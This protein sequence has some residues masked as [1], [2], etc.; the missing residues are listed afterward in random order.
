MDKINFVFKNNGDLINNDVVLPFG[1][2]VLKNN[3]CSITVKPKS[4]FWRLGLRLSKTD[5]IQFFHPVS[6][7]KTPEFN[8]YIDVHLS[9][10]FW[11]PQGWVD[12]N[13]LNLAQ[14]NIPNE[15]HILQLDNSFDKNDEIFWNINFDENTSEIKFIVTKN[16]IL[17]GIKTFHIDSDF[18]YFQFFAWADNIPFELETKIIFNEIATVSQK[19]SQILELENELNIRI[20]KSLFKLENDQIVTLVLS[21]VTIRKESKLSNLEKIRYLG[22]VN[23]EIK[24]TS[25]FSGLNDLMALSLRNV[26]VVNFDF[27]G[28]L[29]HL[30]LLDLSENKI[31]SIDFIKNLKS[32]Q[33]LSL[34]YNKIQDISIL[35]KLTSLQRLDLSNN[36]ISKLPILDKLRALESLVISNNLIEDLEPLTK[37]ESLRVLDIR[38]NKISSVEAISKIRKL[39]DLKINGNVF[40]SELSIILNDID[41]HLTTILN[42]ISKKSDQEQLEVSLPTKVLFLGNH[43]S[44]KSSLLSYFLNKMISKTS[45]THIV[46]I[47]RYFKSTKNSIPDAILYDFG[48]QDYYHG[49]YRAF[50]SPGSIYMILWNP[51]NNNNGKRKD[52]NGLYT[53]DF[54]LEYWLSQ[55]KYF[56]QEKFNCEPDPTVLI[57]TFSDKINQ[58][59]FYK[60]F[61]EVRIENYFHLS[62]AADVESSIA[63]NYEKTKNRFGLE[64]LN[65]TFEELVEFKKIKFKRPR[66]YVEFFEFVLNA[67][68]TTDHIGKSIDELLPFYKHPIS[69][70]AKEFLIDDLD[71]LYKRGLVLFYKDSM[72]DKVWLN[73]SALVQ[74]VY[75]HVLSREIIKTNFGKVKIEDFKDVQN[76]IIELLKSQK[77]IYYHQ[78]GINNEPEYIVPNYLPLASAPDSKYSLFSFGLEVPTFVLKFKNFVPFGLINQFICFF[79]ELPESKMFWR[80][81]L[82][83]TIGEGTKVMIHINFELLEIKVHCG[84]DRKM[85]I[86]ERHEIIKYLFFS[87]IGLY[88]DMEIFDFEEFLIYERSQIRIDEENDRSENIKFKNYLAILNNP[89]CRPLDLFISLDDSKFIN[90]SRLC[91]ISDSQYINAIEVS[92]SRDFLENESSIIVYPFQPFTKN[93]LKRTRKV[94]ISYSK[95]DLSFIET[96]KKYLKSLVEDGLIEEPWYCTY[97]MA[98]SD[99]DAIIQKKFE[100]ADIIFFMVSAN[101][102]ATTYVQEVE[103]KNA[104]DRWSKDGSVKIIPILLTQYRFARKGEYNLAKFTAL[105]YSLYPVSQFAKEDSA[106]YVVTE[107][108]RIMIENDF[109]PGTL[110][111]NQDLINEFEKIMRERN[112][113]FKRID[114]RGSNI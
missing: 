113:S 81:Q 102:M 107:A 31:E 76:E 18:K 50:L 62:L 92:E 53:L 63:D 65:K 85:S 110:P 51:L 5:E 111:Y 59:I 98:G 7:Y 30:T 17:I 91:T 45:S 101:L 71:Q 3:G 70:R 82:I 43:A 89:Q 47:K 6:R 104:I 105:P 61:S 77:V 24:S 68:V 2:F 41:N 112:V 55:K 100:E 46:D 97:L 86:N 16:D 29:K 114:G 103:I 48:G 58:R 14:Y 90:Y 52:T 9:V 11:Q 67:Y 28:K 83:F 93:N 49:I 8:Q 1:P 108:I 106:W 96:F 27:I 10:G 33:V 38:G 40:E 26:K 56:E 74:Y 64:Y 35:A 60:Y 36:R 13:I 21:N 57:Q 69:D 22:L 54:S 94:V 4:D 109:D 84:F 37:L 20:D 19:P 66:W 78:H 80:D 34:S 39:S 23:V 12:K 99:W 72:S 15:D 73:P 25:I 95:K 79:G 42:L 32:V 87:M 88:W 44:G 75:D